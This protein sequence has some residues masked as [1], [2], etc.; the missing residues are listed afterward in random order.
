MKE[1]EF[2]VTAQGDVAS[3][4]QFLNEGRNKSQGCVL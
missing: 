4:S 3:K 1:T 2:S